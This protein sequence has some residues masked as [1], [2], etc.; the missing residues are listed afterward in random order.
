VGICFYGCDFDVIGAE[1]I[2]QKLENVLI[3]SILYYFVIA[4]S[5]LPKASLHIPE[6]QK[7][8]ATMR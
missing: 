3:L 8:Q 6:H 5:P 7:R 2:R 4:H 1:K